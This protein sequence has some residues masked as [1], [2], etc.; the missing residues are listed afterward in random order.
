MAPIPTIASTVVPDNSCRLTGI[1]DARGVKALDVEFDPETGRVSTVQV[2]TDQ[3]DNRFAWLPGGGPAWKTVSAY[4]DQGNL[5]CTTDALGNET[6][7]TYNSYGQQTRIVDP[8]G[9]TTTNRY[10]DATGLL[11]WTEDPAGTRSNFSYVPGTGNLRSVAGHDGTILSTFEYNQFGEVIAASSFA[12]PTSY[13]VYDEAGDLV[14]FDPADP[15]G[16]SPVG[17]LVS[18]QAP[19]TGTR[20]A[21]A[22]SRLF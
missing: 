7:Y 20:S 13:L 18:F 21:P 5:K 4:D 16:V 3:F 14:S 17:D 8:L 10:N 22:D 1:T 12:G 9:N 2:P 19:I 11:E 6:R 15:M